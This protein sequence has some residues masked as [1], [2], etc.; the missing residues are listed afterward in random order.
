METVTKEEMLLTI[1]NFLYKVTESIISDTKKD[2]ELNSHYLVIDKWINGK[3]EVT[4]L[5][6][7]GRTIL[8]GYSK[9]GT[10]KPIDQIQILEANGNTQFV[11]RFYNTIINL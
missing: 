10:S 3:G 5:I 6:L 2:I 8:D 1:N 9:Q 11:E 4:K 7:T